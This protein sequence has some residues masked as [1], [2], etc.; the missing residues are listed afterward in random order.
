MTNY[1][2]TFGSSNTLIVLYVFKITQFSCQH[3]IGFFF[4][5][6][7]GY[8]FPLI[9]FPIVSLC[10]TDFS[11]LVKEKLPFSFRSC[12]LVFGFTMLPKNTVSPNTGLKTNPGLKT[13][14]ARIHFFPYSLSSFKFFQ[15]TAE[16]AMLTGLFFPP[17]LS[18][19][20]FIR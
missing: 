8:F 16:Q 9:S 20:K 7:I 17:P 15:N 10:L 6:Y 5:F 11:P 18:S 13:A 19:R 14:A 1:K 4:F 12:K 3:C 2:T